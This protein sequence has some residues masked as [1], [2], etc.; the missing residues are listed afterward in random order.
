MHINGMRRGVKDWYV[1]Q[2]NRMLEEA[3]KVEPLK[4]VAH[5]RKGHPKIVG[6]SRGKSERCSR[7]S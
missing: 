5:A 3:S 7:G 4:A 2:A 6:G 1:L